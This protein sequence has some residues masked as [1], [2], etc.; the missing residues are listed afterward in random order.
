MPEE[1]L[2]T[3]LEEI[4]SVAAE[5]VEMRKDV[6]LAIAH[7]EDVVKI[8]ADVARIDEHLRK[9]DEFMA[10]PPAL[11]ERLAALE[12]KQE[13]EHQEEVAGVKGAGTAGDPKHREASR[14]EAGKLV[15]A[16]EE[17]TETKLVPIRERLGLLSGIAKE[18]QGTILVLL[19]VGSLVG[20]ALLF[21]AAR[22]IG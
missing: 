2:A 15:V 13:R 20:A 4:R 7:G 17:R 9:I 3:V 5:L 21:I 22:A 18:N 1:T 19:T 12:R 14:D 10:G 6:T 8:Q 16:S 11:T